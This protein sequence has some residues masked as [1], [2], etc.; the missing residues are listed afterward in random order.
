MPVVGDGEV[1]GAGQGS[2]SGSGRKVA[3]ERAF[4]WRWRRVGK[5]GGGGCDARRRLRGNRRFLKTKKKKIKKTRLDGV[6]PRLHPFLWDFFPGHVACIDWC[7][8]CVPNNYSITDNQLSNQII[9]IN[10]L[11]LTGGV[12]GGM[13][14]MHD[15]PSAK[16]GR[17]VGV[18]AS[19]H[20]DGLDGFLLYNGFRATVVDVG[21]EKD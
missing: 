5:K 21:E 6:N 10:L 20:Q 14:E 3:K 9:Y 2:G 7:V 15:D 1:F 8:L 19:E 16:E 4:A 12:L 11:A 13:D 18:K 17:V